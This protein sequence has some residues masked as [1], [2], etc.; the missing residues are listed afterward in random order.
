MINDSTTRV[1]PGALSTLDEKRGGAGS[2]PSCTQKLFKVF[3]CVC[4]KKCAA[5]P[6]PQEN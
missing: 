6:T 3:V 5:R 4:A 1:G 2:V